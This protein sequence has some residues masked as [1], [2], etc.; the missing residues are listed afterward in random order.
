MI[1]MNLMAD[2][3]A[4]ASQ[5]ET[6]GLTVIEAMASSLPVVC[7]NDESFNDTVIDG[8]NGITEVSEG[9]RG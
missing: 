5:T 3:F 2:V 9:G 8:L 6:Q 7:I 4:T 1:S